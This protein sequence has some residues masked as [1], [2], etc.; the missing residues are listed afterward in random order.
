MRQKKKSLRSCYSRKRTLRVRNAQARPEPSSFRVT[1]CPLSIV[2]PT[3]ARGHWGRGG[4]RHEDAPLHEP[5][6]CWSLPSTFLLPLRRKNQ[7]RARS[8]CLTL[9][10]YACARRPHSLPMARRGHEFRP[11]SDDDVFY[12]FLQKQKICKRSPSGFQPSQCFRFSLSPALLP[13]HRFKKK[14][15]EVF[16]RN[17]HV[18]V[19]MPFHCSLRNKNEKVYGS[20]WHKK[21]YKP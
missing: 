4:V 1:L 12:L 11:L 10:L 15:T 8:V 2:E 21:H 9:A 17:L 6:Q 16:F 18:S 5:L 7:P 20:I 14:S 3:P 19:L 13:S